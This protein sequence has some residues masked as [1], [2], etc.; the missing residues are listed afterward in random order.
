[1]R[2]TSN[3][4]GQYLHWFS[5]T[6]VFIGFSAILITN[7]YFTS[8]S[9]GVFFTTLYFIFGD[10]LLR[11]S[12]PRSVWNIFAVII[13]VYLAYQSF[14]GDL[15]LVGNAISFVVYLQIV[16]I[17]SPKDIRDWYQIYLLSFLH[18]LASTTISSDMTFAVP[19]IVYLI[20]ATWTLT[21]FNI[22]LQQETTSSSSTRHS[23]IDRLLRSTD[24]VTPRFF[25]TT[26]LLSVFIMIF[27]LVIFF[28]FPRI[29][30]KNFLRRVSPKQDIS[31]YSGEVEL[32]TIGRIKEN[33]TIALRVE[34]PEKTIDNVDIEE[35]YWRGTSSDYFDGKKWSQS[36]SD[37]HPIYVDADDNILKTKYPTYPGG[38]ILEYSVLLEALNTPILFASDRLLRVTWDKPLIEKFLRR[39][40]GIDYSDEYGSY[41]FQSTQNF[42]S[43]LTYRAESMIGQPDAELLKLVDNSNIPYSLKQTYLQLPPLDKDVIEVL[44][45]IPVQGETV[46]ERARSIQSFIENNY[47]YTVD[48]QDIGIK[49]PM[50]FFFLERKKGHC[51]Y[52]STAL[53]VA[54]RYHEIPSRQVIG[55]RGGDYNPIGNYLAIRQNDAHG[56]AEVYFHK[57]GWIR[58]DPSPASADSMT[59]QGSIAKSFFQMTDY[60]RL[61]WNKYIVEYDLRSQANIIEKI[62]KHLSTWIK[63]DNSKDLDLTKDSDEEATIKK[64]SFKN[65][66]LMVSFFLLPILG[67]LLYL[68]IKKT[69]KQGIHRELKET[70]R[71][72]AKKG[73]KKERFST[74]REFSDEIE[75]KLGAMPSLNHLTNMYYEERFGNISHSQGEWQKQLNELKKNLRASK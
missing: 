45:N 8:V 67:L 27:A 10:K 11:F 37:R 43:D 28:I 63:G 50:R 33:N 14:F 57:Y 66:I 74:I 38:K 54:L 70:L 29:S 51:G 34:L 15:D 21:L 31:G 46:Y 71:I 44:K 40:L 36:T 19:F 56:W 13:F 61:R 59:L 17:L 52:F 49:N 18:I 30:M 32:G 68:F 73:F 2:I 58:F 65:L 75:D 60:L 23:L 35:L 72:L 20:V 47:D 16:K 48:V 53:I 42:S 6:L 4:F 25:A 41:H 26:S 22:R 7:S 3:T 24:V 12:P 64:I 5:C 9:L 1:M 55:F 39:S 69:H 62:G